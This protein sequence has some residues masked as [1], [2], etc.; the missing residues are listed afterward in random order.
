M[1]VL[2]ESPF[3]LLFMKKELFSESS[4]RHFLRATLSGAVVVPSVGWHAA[5]G[6]ESGSPNAFHEPPRPG[7]AQQ[8]TLAL[9][10]HVFRPLPPG[11]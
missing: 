2:W 7:Q 10:L 3:V 11:G 1:I 5:S 4:R 8:V 9:D 6:A